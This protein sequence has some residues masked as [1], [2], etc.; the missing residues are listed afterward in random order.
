MRK[1]ET[2]RLERYLTHLGIKHDGIYI[3]RIIKKNK[4]ERVSIG[5][6]TPQFIPENTL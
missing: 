1:T 6:L 5:S 2:D 3:V 4:T